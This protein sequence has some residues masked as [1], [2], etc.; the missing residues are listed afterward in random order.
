[1]KKILL[2]ISFSVCLLQAFS[3]ITPITTIQ[4][5]NQTD[6]QNNVDLSYK[7]GDTVT[8]QGV[9]TFDPCHYA[10]SGSAGY[11]NR[12]G[13]WLEEI[14]GGPW[15]GVEVMI[16]PAAIGGTNSLANLQALDA[17]TNFINNFSVGNVVQCTGIVKTF[18]N[19]TQINLLPISSTI[20]TVAAVPTP[21]VV[22]IDSLMMLNTATSINEPQYPSGEQWEGVY[23]QLN[24]AQVTN[25]STTTSS[26]KWSVKDG[27]G[28]T[29][30][31]KD[32]IS[33]VIDNGT[34][35]WY[36][37]GVAGVSQTPTTFASI[38][39]GTMLSYLRGILFQSQ[40]ALGV[41]DYYIAPLTLSDIGPVTWAAPVISNVH[42][43]ISAPTASQIETITANV[44]DDSLVS[45]VELYYAFGLSNSTFVGPVSM[46]GGPVYSANI[47][48][49]ITDSTWVKYYIKATDNFGH[50]SY[51][52]NQNATNSYYLAL[53]SGINSIQDIQGNHY[54]NGMS[55]YAGDSVAMDVTG[56]VMASAATND[57]GYV[58]IQN[59]SGP[60]RGIFL[61][62]VSSLHRGDQIHITAAKI[63]EI[64]GSNNMSTVGA[65]TLS[66]ITYNLVSSG[67]PLYAPVGSIYLNVDSIMAKKLP[68]AEPFEAVLIS[69]TNV[70]VVDT[71]P[72]RITTPPS[73]FGEFSIYTSTPSTLP[74]PG[75]RCDDYSNDIQFGFNVD[76]LQN[77][78]VLCYITGI[79]KYDFGNW[80]ILPRNLSDICGFQTAY[81]KDI[82]TFK[83]TANSV[84]YFGLVNQSA[85]TVS[86]SGLPAG[87]NITALSATATYSGQSINPPA[88]STQDFTNPVQYTVTAVD[89]STSV[90]TVTVTVSPSGIEENKE[91]NQLQLFPNPAN[92]LLH[93]R[94]TSSFAGRNEM[95]LINE[96][97][98]KV[99]TQTVLTQAGENNFSMNLN[100]LATG[101]YVLEIKNS[102]RVLNQKVSITK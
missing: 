56:I 76:S 12:L 89:N 64:N 26:F 21:P 43:S 62:G 39:S 34:Y 41:M 81:P 7:D 10:Q 75:L 100:G 22:A 71:N 18:Y 46:S 27:L 1:M 79:L 2:F 51:Y 9:V 42:R 68:F 69:L 17:A 54:S 3:Q 82:L 99:K 66:N 65:T 60:Y 25:T 13:T 6:L 28:N 67:N 32:N 74:A 83:V 73:N 87:T 59:G 15:S 14:T 4:H 93:I 5:I 97:G 57:L 78:D 35:D 58:T 94:L 55:I 80:K 19:N 84:D 33:G 45:T 53:N 85:K 101:N 48:A 95:S 70:T 72:D 11:P 49:T 37:G 30:A 96:L 63:N 102:S 61:N 16:E 98:Q 88:V 92:D 50:V 86:V 52:P 47:P 38:P 44:T 20:V 36:C 24:N 29:I 40:N 91:T 77:G 23:I 90:Y 31:I 8:I